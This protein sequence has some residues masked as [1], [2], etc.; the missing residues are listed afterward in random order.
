[1]EASLKR[2]IENCLRDIFELLESL[3][4]DPYSSHF[5]G[6]LISLQSAQG[7]EAL[8]AVRNILKMYRGAGSF[9]DLI[10]STPGNFYPRENMVL[11]GLRNQLYRLCVEYVEEVGIV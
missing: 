1:M 10:L 5:Q 4:Y 2:E 11:D 9:N 6:L 3:Q 8:K 7:E